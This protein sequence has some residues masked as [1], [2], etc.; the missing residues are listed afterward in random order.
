MPDRPSAEE[1]SVYLTVM[2][3]MGESTAYPVTNHKLI[4]ATEIAAAANTD[5]I[6]I[7]SGQNQL[8]FNTWAKHLP[9][10]FDNG[11]R[12]IKEPVAN[13]RP[14]FGWEQQD[15]K[16]KVG[17]APGQMNIAGPGTFVAMMGFESPL[18]PQRSVV[19]FY[20][21]KP[22]DLTRIE[23]SLVDP[24]RLA[25]ISGDLVIVG[26]KSLQATRASHTYVVGDLAVTTQLRW[27]LSDHPIV[28]ALG[29]LLL[30][31][32]IAAL[33]YRPLKL[34]KLRFTKVET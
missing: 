28:V 7:G 17:I 11:A 21:D 25:G 6:V 20:A 5:L 23:D 32:L 4:R 31:I 9:I 19:F 24:V 10:V 33:L 34:L 3:K 2:A 22:A 18:K 8:L 14:A 12:T 30:A 27:L 15:D 1:I 29:I 26:E 16:T 13:W